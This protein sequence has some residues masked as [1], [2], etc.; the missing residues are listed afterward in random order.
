MPSSEFLLLN[1]N[2]NYDKTCKSYKNTN[3]FTIPNSVILIPK[4]QQ[5]SNISCT[6]NQSGW[7]GEKPKDECDETKLPYLHRSWAIFIFQWFIMTYFNS[8]YEH[9][10]QKLV[11]SNIFLQQG[12]S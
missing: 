3:L 2:K 7:A 4:S 6:E 1:E 11:C 5:E 8:S 10:L 9:F 12:K